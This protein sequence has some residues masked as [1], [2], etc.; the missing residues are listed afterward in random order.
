[1]KTYNFKVELTCCDPKIYRVIAIGQNATLYGLS[2]AIQN[3][4]NFYNDHLHSFFMSGKEYDRA[5]EYTI[6]TNA[7]DFKDKLPLGY[8]QETKIKSLKLKLRQKF[9]YLYDF[10]DNLNMDITYLGE[11]KTTK[12]G[13]KNFQ[14]LE[15]AGKAPDQ[16]DIRR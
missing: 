3:G 4:F 16:Y 14:I 13:V 2:N 5:S 8:T 7:N 6:K 11:G 1:M 12:K 10:G 15:N 9:L